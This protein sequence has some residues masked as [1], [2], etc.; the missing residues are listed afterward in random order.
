[1]GHPYSRPMS[2]DIRVKLPVLGRNGS[3]SLMAHGQN[4]LGV[5]AGSASVRLDREGIERELRALV[6]GR[7]RFGEHERMLYAT[8]ASLYQVEP[9]GVVEPADIEDAAAVVRWC[10]RHGVAVL[11]RG[12]G[13][14][15]AGQ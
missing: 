8:D 11:P 6:R 4:G 7:V 2:T 5:G 1:C 9:I 15:L 10:G 3:S 14:S 13:T 12:G